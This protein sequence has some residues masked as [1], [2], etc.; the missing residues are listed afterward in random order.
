[1]VRTIGP[2]WEDNHRS[3][4]DCELPGRIKVIRIA[5][6]AGE[7]KPVAASGVTEVAWSWEYLHTPG[8]RLPGGKKTP[9]EVAHSDA[10]AR[11]CCYFQ[12]LS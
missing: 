11:L 2:N 6:R 3:V 12:E 1:M 10:V 5:L 9:Q 7:W 8:R 4:C